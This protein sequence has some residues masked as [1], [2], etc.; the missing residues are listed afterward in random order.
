MSSWGL[1]RSLAFLLHSLYSNSL[2]PAL[3]NLKRTSC[4]LAPLQMPS[5]SFWRHCTPSFGHPGSLHHLVCSR[6]PTS[7]GE[8]RFLV[9]WADGDISVAFTASWT[10][11]TDL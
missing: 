1:H 6:S 11:S 8:D 4:S 5:D 10:T 9:N 2:S 7:E 3:K